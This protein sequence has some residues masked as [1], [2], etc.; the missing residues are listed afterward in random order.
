MMKVLG[1]FRDGGDIVIVA[2]GS[3]VPCRLIMNGLPAEL[4]VTTRVAVSAPTVFG[5]NAMPIWQEAPPA[6]TVAQLSV[7]GKSV[8]FVP[9]N[10]IAFVRAALPWLKIVKNCCPLFSPESVLGR[11]CVT[12][13]AGEKQA[14]AE[15]V[16]LMITR[17]PLLSLN[18]LF[19]IA[20]GTELIRQRPCELFEVANDV[21][22]PA[23]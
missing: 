2:G 4:L 22:R 14:E 8:G 10:E 3:P 5:A 19:G 9:V 6:A 15:F 1:K 16:G 21:V 20:P 17:N 23:R 13:V 18:E 11:V 12:V 7:S